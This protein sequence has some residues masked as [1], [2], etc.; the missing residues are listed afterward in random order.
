MITACA[1]GVSCT[2]IMFFSSI[3]PSFFASMML[4]LPTTCMMSAFLRR[5]VVSSSVIS[6]PW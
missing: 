1:N 3:S 4:F 5:S 2:C 6:F